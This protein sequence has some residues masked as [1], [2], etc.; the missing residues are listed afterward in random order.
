VPSLRYWAVPMPLCVVR[1]GG[2]ATLHL[3]PRTWAEARCHSPPWVV[4]PGSEERGRRPP[5]FYSSAARA[6]RL[7]W[8]AA[9]LAGVHRATGSWRQSPPP[10]TSPTPTVKIFK[11][12]YGVRFLTPTVR[13]LD[14][15][16]SPSV[17]PRAF[18]HAHVVSH[19]QCHTLGHQYT[20][21]N[22]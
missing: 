12:S 21:V 3:V 22:G 1:G 16:S 5:S 20:Q 4:S 7:A 8:V 15:L 10:N 18:V 11:D 19:T 13:P 6:P 17:R 2:N 9:W 14:H